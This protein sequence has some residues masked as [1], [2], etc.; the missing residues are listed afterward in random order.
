MVSVIAESASLLHKAIS[1][2]SSKALRE[3]HLKKEQDI[4][5]KSLFKEKDFLAMLPTGFGKSL[6]FQVFAI[7]KSLLFVESTSSHGSVLVVSPLMS[8]ISDQIEEARSLGLTALEIEHPGIFENLPR[9]PD[10]LFTLAETVCA[11]GFRDVMRKRQD[12]HLVVVDE[13]HTIET[14][15]GAR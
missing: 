4:A 15:P 9:L 1:F 11:R 10:I 2:L 8:I 3:I 12:V 5:I 14:W 6:V 13:S 7:V